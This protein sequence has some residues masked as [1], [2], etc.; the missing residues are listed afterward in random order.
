MTCGCTQTKPTCSS[1]PTG[2]VS[3]C[4]GSGTTCAAKLPFMVNWSKA[5]VPYPKGSIV[6]H[7]NCVWGQTSGMGE[8]A[9][10]GTG[11][12]GWRPFDQALLVSLI[13]NPSAVLLPLIKA[14]LAD[15]N[16]TSNIQLE[17][18]DGQ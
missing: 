4:S 1:V 7:G 15:P 10:P 3:L 16:V 8:Y 9:P 2:T 5:C 14:A 6:V 11:Q 12:S 17:A 18:C 13:T